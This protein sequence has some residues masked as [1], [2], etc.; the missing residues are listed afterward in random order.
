M[1]HRLNFEEMVFNLIIKANNQMINNQV[2]NS[3]PMLHKNYKGNKFTGLIPHLDGIVLHSFNKNTI[4]FV[5]FFIYKCLNVE[6][7]H[8]KIVST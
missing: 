4:I 2:K 7:K 3:M 1:E 6:T 8:L 5:V